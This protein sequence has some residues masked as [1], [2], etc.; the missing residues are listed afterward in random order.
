MRAILSLMLA[1]TVI[2][3]A[4]A[5]DGWVDST[6]LTVTQAEGGGGM[7]VETKTSSNTAIGDTIEDV[8]SASQATTTANGVTSSGIISIGSHSVYTPNS[9]RTTKIGIGTSVRMP[10][11]FSTQQGTQSLLTPGSI[12]AGTG[13]TLNKDNKEYAYGSSADIP[14]GDGITTLPE[15]WID[16]DTSLL[17]GFDIGFWMGI[18]DIVNQGGLEYTG[19][20]EFDKGVIVG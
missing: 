20:M 12:G 1:L 16:P 2:S 18:A 13:T 9:I 7:T 4:S 8:Y 11:Y 6:Y 3:V 5:S 14:L 15:M 10:G 17:S 19:T